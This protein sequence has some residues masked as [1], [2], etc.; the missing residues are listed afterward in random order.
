M[1]PI[2]DEQKPISP[3]PPSL[4]VGNKEEGRIAQIEDI[5]KRSEENPELKPGTEGV[6]EIRTEQPQLTEQDAKAG[7]SV[8][9]EVITPTLTPSGIVQLPDQSRVAKRSG[10]LR[11]AS[12][13]IS[14][15]REKVEKWF[16]NKKQ[17]VLPSS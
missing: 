15:L 2:K 5:L 4:G 12:S 1:D 13:W 8:S 16:L 17:E 3:T 14:K 11:E 7:L 6:V 10:N 9:G